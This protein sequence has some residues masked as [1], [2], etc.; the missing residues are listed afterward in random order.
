M[1][2]WGY[3]KEHGWVVLDRSIPSN[4]PGLKA[5]LLFF[6]CRDSAT[7][8]EKR[9]KWNPP[10]Y[11][12]APNYIRGLAHAESVEAGA[13]FEALKALWPEFQ[14]QIQREQREAEERAEAVRVQEEKARKQAAGEKKKQE[15]AVDH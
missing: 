15:A 9:E 13:E 7:F 11:T 12:F 4:G 6:R 14:R 3:S 8:V 10:L 5:D 1:Q 2:W